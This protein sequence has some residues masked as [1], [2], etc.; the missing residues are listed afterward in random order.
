ML[1][2]VVDIE[3]NESFAVRRKEKT[4]QGLALIPNHKIS[5]LDLLLHRI[6]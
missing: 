3:E 5:F 6:A 1:E 4:Y 2:M